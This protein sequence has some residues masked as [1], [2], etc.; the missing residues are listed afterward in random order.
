MN[1]TPFPNTLRRISL[2]ALFVLLLA[3]TA[4][5]GSSSGGSGDSNGIG[6]PDDTEDSDDGADDSD[7]SADDS[8]DIPPVDDLEVDVSFDGTTI[9]LEWDEREGVE[10]NV[11]VTSDGNCDIANYAE[12][13]DAQKFSEVSS[14][15]SL[16]DSVGIDRFYVFMEAIDEEGN[17]QIAELGAFRLTVQFPFNE[18]GIDW[19]ADRTTNYDDGD[20]DQRRQ[21][22]EAVAGDWPGQ[23]GMRLNSRDVL[24][25]EGNLEKVGA[26][27][28]GFD[29][30]KLD[31]EGNELP[32]DA[33]EWVC[34]NDN[35]TGL[36]WEVKTNDGGLRD[37]D[38]NYTWYDS[39]YE[40]LDG[41]SAGGTD[42]GDCDGSRCDTEG[43][44]EAVNAEGLCGASDWRMPTIDE[45]HSLVHM[46]RTNPA[47][48]ADFFP[49]TI[50]AR[51]WSSSLD[52]GKDFRAW[53]VRSERG[54]DAG[55][56]KNRAA[57]V[58]LVRVAD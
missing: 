42:G 7:D 30:T 18:T 38:H 57:A 26:G 24:A 54:R 55:M 13:A 9:E 32:F 34:V 48:D 25:R 23:D 35:H 5:G 36:I 41:R 29:F 2:C 11:I 49:N 22:C 46:G 56:D 8:D 33:G 31:A 27:A 53:Y 21:N 15:F 10:Y 45:L 40:D 17:T 14:P 47:I 12:C 6:D 28:A 58:R 16:D 51:F 43:Y 4:C 20:A 39:D 1:T 50:V 19:C 52:A 3:L 44:V 37:Q